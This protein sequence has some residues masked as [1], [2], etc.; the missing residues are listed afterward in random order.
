MENPADCD[1]PLVAEDT[2]A[3]SF[4]L[5]SSPLTKVKLINE[6][7]EREAALGVNDNVSWHSEYKDSAWIFVGKTRTI[8]WSGEILDTDE[9]TGC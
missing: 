3:S 5:F 6:L 1:I 2:E 9:S 7:N 8:L 4:S